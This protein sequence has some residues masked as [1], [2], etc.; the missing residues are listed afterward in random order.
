M[1]I[2]TYILSSV[3]DVIL[4]ILVHIKQLILKTYHSTNYKLN[5]VAIKLITQR[6]VES[7][8]DDFA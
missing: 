4:N 6:P 8:A 1:R 3:I 5:T 2:P 7:R